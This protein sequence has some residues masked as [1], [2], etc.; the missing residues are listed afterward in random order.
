MPAKVARGIKKNVLG[1][2]CK[3]RCGNRQCGCRK[4]KQTC[5]EDCH[6]EAEKCRNRDNGVL[7]GTFAEELVGNPKGGGFNLEDPTLVTRGDTFFEPPAVAPTKKVLEATVDQE[8]VAPDSNGTTSYFSLEP[9][10][11]PL[12]AI[13][14]RKRILSNTSGFF[15]G[16]TPIKE[17]SVEG[18]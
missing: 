3:G 2:T 13:K 15:S 7:E 9:G 12:P 6:C 10:Q 5:S 14:K 1:C 16:C 8:N 4:Q 18:F 11:I 17:D